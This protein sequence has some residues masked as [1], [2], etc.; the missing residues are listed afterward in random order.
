MAC[1]NM[2]GFHSVSLCTFLVEPL[3]FLS[4]FKMEEK[5]LAVSETEDICLA[6]LSISDLTEVRMKASLKEA[7]LPSILF[8]PT[9]KSAQNCAGY[10]AN[11]YIYIYIL[12]SKTIQLAHRI[13]CKHQIQKS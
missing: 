9:A 12:C 1:F 8:L 11:I 13:I 7:G 10:A 4:L 6:V 3:R 5:I 2:A